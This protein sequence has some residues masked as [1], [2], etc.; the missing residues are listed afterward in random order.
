MCKI[1]VFGYGTVTLR[2]TFV[3]I[4]CDK[5]HNKINLLIINYRTENP[6]PCAHLFGYW[7]QIE[8]SGSVAHDYNSQ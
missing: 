1:W 3:V 7:E 5:K 6:W 4:S 8:L 2:T